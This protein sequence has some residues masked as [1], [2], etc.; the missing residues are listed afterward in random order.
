[1]V[2]LHVHITS[3][4]ERAKQACL[5]AI[6]SAVTLVDLTHIRSSE[7]D[8]CVKRRISMFCALTGNGSQEPVFVI[9]D[10][11][12][13]VGTD[14]FPRSSVLEMFIGFSNSLQVLCKSSLSASLYSFKQA[15]DKEDITNVKIM[16]SSHGR[17]L[18]QVYQELLFTSAYSFEYSMIYD[19]VSCDSCPLAICTHTDINTQQAA[20]AKHELSTFLQRLPAVKGDITL[21]RSSVIS[22]W[23]CSSSW[24]HYTR[25]LPLRLY[26][27]MYYSLLFTLHAF[28]WT[29][30]I[31]KMWMFTVYK[32]GTI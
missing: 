2:C 32:T 24:S 14:R 9:A 19:S 7:Y 6:M 29:S 22:G 25:I 11:E 12:N 13:S 18:F 8:I 16:T 17:A 15:I 1:M 4:P 26:L 30:N 3:I 21:L 28:Y 20:D 27:S 5:C 31:V 10:P 23:R